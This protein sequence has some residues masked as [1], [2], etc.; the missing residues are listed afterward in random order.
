[1]GGALDSFLPRV[2]P[3][4]DRLLRETCLG[5]VMRQFL[6]ALHQPV[7]RELFQGVTGGGMQHLSPRGQQTVVCYFL[8]QGMF[9]HIQRS[10][11]SGT[12][13]EKFQPLE[14]QEQCFQ[15][16]GLFP[17]RL[18]QAWRKCST[19]NGSCLQQT[20]VFLW[21]TIN[22]CHQHVL[23]RVRYRYIRLEIPVLDDGTSEFFQEEGIAFR[24]L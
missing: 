11:S 14:V 20:L 3:I 24:L 19:E 18:Q 15:W 13:I 2:I 5:V 12:F 23:N 1:M 6:R 10:L 8:R 16:R 4:V 22:L 7:R 21:K 17:E 9:E